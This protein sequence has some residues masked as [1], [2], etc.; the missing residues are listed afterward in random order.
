MNNKKL[1]QQTFSHIH[2]SAHIRWEDYSM[3]KRQMPRRLTAVT[4]AV[5]AALL[6]A[7]AAAAAAVFTTIRFPA[8]FPNLTEYSAKIYGVEPFQVSLQLPDGCVL[9]DDFIDPE[10]G[11]T[12]WSPVE[13][14]MDG[15]AVG[16]MDYNIF[17]LYPDGPKIHEPGFYRMVYNQIML[18]VQGNWDNDYTVVR[19]DEVSE[20][21]VTKVAW[22][23]DYGNGR[24]DNEIVYRPGILAYN[25]DL[26]VYVNIWFED[27]VFTDEQI[28]SI[29]ASITLSR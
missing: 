9:S 11:Q 6:L 16:V 5:I 24:T 1:Y 28:E 25:T 17:E 2:S 20:N 18:Q 22:I 19:Q 12:G 7:G 29:A 13:I 8:T 14:Q 26:L 4:V 23:Q 3:K 15:Q 27:G 21:A 10:N